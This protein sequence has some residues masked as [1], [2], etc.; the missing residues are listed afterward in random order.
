M[1]LGRI[2]RKTDQMNC[3]ISVAEVH[4]PQPGVGSTYFATGSQREHMHRFCACTEHPWSVGGVSCY[5]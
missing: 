1:W 2:Q 4:T 3:A 5:Y